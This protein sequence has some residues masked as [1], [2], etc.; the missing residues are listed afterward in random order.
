MP[1]DMTT[2]KRRIGAIAMMEEENTSDTKL[3]SQGPVIPLSDEEIQQWSKPLKNTLI[4]KVHGIRVN[5]KLLEGKLI[6]KAWG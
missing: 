5:Y 6:R 3:P 2:L 4:V 1:L